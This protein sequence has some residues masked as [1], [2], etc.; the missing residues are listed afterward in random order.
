MK[1]NQHYF[2]AIEMWPYTFKSVNRC[3]LA[4]PKT[5]NEVQYHKKMRNVLE[6]GISN[7]ARFLATAQLY[8]EDWLTV[9]LIARVEFLEDITFDIYTGADIYVKIHIVRSDEK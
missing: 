5:L 8:S 6:A 2:S 7:W 3:G 4:K 1:W 9:I